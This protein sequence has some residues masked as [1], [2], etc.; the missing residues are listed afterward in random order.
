[1]HLPV[2]ET[3]RLTIRPF[4]P[5]DLDAAHHLFVNVGWANADESLEEQLALRRDYLEWN[6]LNHLMLARL[7]Q[8]PFGDRAVVWKEKGH[9]NGRQR[10][11]R[12]VG[13]VGVVP[14]WGPFEQLPA[15]G[16]VTHGLNTPEMG[17][18][19]AVHPAYQ[20]QG[21]ATE[22]A[23]ALIQFLFRELRLK[24]VVALTGYDNLPS[25]R[26][27][28]KLGMTLERNPQKEPPWF[29]VI[30]ILENPLVFPL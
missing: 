1:M 27:M 12:L 5:K 10:D 21:I 11:G 14:A 26:V 17:L 22:A 29:Q 2:L 16:G 18:M 13:A 20:Q 19:W 15:F 28:Q 24:R 23:H 6:A 7:M 30:G 25:Q 4:T 3:A 8:P 9:E